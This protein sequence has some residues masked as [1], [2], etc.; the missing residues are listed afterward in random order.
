MPLSARDLLWALVLVSTWGGSFTVIK[1]GLGD[2][3]PMMLGALRY[4]LSA[5]PALLFFPMPRVP[6]RGWLAYGMT[7]G[8][9]QFALLFLAVRW[10]LPAGVASV[11]LQAQAFFTLVFARWFLGEHIRP[12][13]WLGMALAGLGLGLLMAPVSTDVHNHSAVAY[14]LILG[15]AASWAASNVVL[16]RIK[17]ATPPHDPLDVLGFIVWTSIVPPLPFAG[18]SWWT[19]EFTEPAA[20]LQG[21]S[22]WGW[23]SILYLAWGGT[24]LGNGIFSRLLGRYPVAR[25]APITL[26]VPVLGL[27]VAWWVLGEHI[28]ARQ[29]L[30]CTVIML[31]LIVAT[32][33][34]PTR[35]RSKHLVSANGLNTTRLE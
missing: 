23:M 5:F 13:Q 30:G 21:I 26:L 4:V 9:G 25:V 3:P 15:A 6:L 22:G 7:V 31:G 10:G 14:L 32:I 27:F 24:L 1:L 2:V 16:K 28:S 19:G 12:V 34:M 35:G 17:Q 8:V 18:L 29:Y 33:S 20:V 11:A